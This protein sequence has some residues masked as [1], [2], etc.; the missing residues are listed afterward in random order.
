[1]ALGR[2]YFKS[3]MHKPAPL[4]FKTTNTII[5]KRFN[6]IA[7]R[8]AYIKNA[9]RYYAKKYGKGKFSIYETSNVFNTSFG[10]TVVIKK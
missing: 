3:G 5:E 1:M 10:A 4:E 8:D 6:T 9:E 2:F 7:E